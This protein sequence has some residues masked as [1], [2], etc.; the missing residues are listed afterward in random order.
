MLVRSVVEGL[1]AP[2]LV[3]AFWASRPQWTEDMRLWRAVGDAAVVLLAL[4]LAMGPAGRL[5]PAVARVA[6]W[7]RQVGIWTA[8]TSLTTACLSSGAGAFDLGRLIRV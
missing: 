4:S 7:R 2:V 5:L 6:R 3:G 1:L 8:L